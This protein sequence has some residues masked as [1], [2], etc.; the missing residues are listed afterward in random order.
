MLTFIKEILTWW[1]RQTLGTRLNTIFYGKFVG[2]DQFGNKYYENKKGKRWVIYKN[3][4]EATNIPNNWY[5]WIHY[6][7]N[8]IEN[9]H[10]LKE[11]SWQKPHKPNQTGTNNAYHPNKS[12]KLETK[13][14]NTWKN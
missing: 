8:K 11:F 14:Y 4:V 1:N 13:K 7:K 12:K 10:N 3:E 2:E 5:S 9:E 6:T